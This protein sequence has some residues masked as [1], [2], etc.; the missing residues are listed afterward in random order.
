MLEPTPP[1]PPPSV[2][3]DTERTPWTGVDILLVFV[4]GLVGAVLAGALLYPVLDRLDL[5][6]TTIETIFTLLTYVS[7][8]VVAGAFVFRR[9]RASAGDVGLNRVPSTTLLLMIPVAF[10]VMIVNGFLVLILRELFGDVSTVEDQ[11]NVEG[12]TLD[13]VEITFFFITTTIAAPVVEEFIFRGMLFRHLRGRAGVL[14][15]MVISSAVF[16]TLHLIPSLLAPL[17]FLGL[18]LA[19]VAQRYDSLFP[20]MVLHAVVNLTAVALLV[21]EYG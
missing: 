15:A 1:S 11:L 10:G 12:E 6:D 13:L 17:F 21:S 18:V 5:T 16:S 19:Y 2:E 9:R 14:W 8:A 7:L 4:I 20:A 3:T